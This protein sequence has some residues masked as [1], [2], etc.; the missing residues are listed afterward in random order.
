MT[1]I[2]SNLCAELDIDGDVLENLVGLQLY[3]MAVDGR[4]VAEHNILVD[5]E[6]KTVFLLAKKTE[7]RYQEDTSE[8]QL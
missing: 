3:V 4:A 5:G 8:R 6:R 1:A 2:L 7:C